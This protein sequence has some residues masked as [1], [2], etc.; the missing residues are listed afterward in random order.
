MLFPTIVDMVALKR[1]F[2]IPYATPF[3]PYPIPDALPSGWESDIY[4]K[5]S[6][7]KVIG[8]E[9][10]EFTI[11]KKGSI[12]FVV[13]GRCRE[14]CD[15][16]SIWEGG[17]NEIVKLRPEM[18]AAVNEKMETPLHEACRQGSLEM[19]KFLVEMDPWV[20]YMVN[21]EIESSL[22]GL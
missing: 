2:N 9:G 4:M 14:Y 20:V 8:G 12:K 18:V 13:R 1:R 7:K 6:Y 21:R 17:A 10:L 5:N 22:S 19:V 15:G 11:K 16:H 3:C